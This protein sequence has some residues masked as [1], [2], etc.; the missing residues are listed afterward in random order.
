MHYKI[1]L[2]ASASDRVRKWFA[3][4]ARDHASRAFRI[5]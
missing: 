5:A 3:P 1:A 4:P 2:L